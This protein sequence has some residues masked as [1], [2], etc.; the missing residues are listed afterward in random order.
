MQQKT[1]ASGISG[2]QMDVSM[3]HSLIRDSTIHHDIGAL[4]VSSIDRAVPV[5][6][7]SRQHISGGRKMH[8]LAIIR[9]YMLPFTAVSKLILL[10]CDQGRCI[11]SRSS[12]PQHEFNILG[13]DQTVFSKSGDRCFHPAETPDIFR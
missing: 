4:P 2:Y 13:L 10:L 9:S 7:Q 12:G 3:L 5:P 8:V 6:A 1:A 11:L